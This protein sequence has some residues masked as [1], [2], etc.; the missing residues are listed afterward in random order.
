M[1]EFLAL[2]RVTLRAY[3]PHLPAAVAARCG[4]TLTDLPALM[5]G[6]D[7]VVLC[8]ANTTEANA[9]VSRELVNR[10]APGALL[11]NVGRSMLVDM[12]A[13]RERLERREIFAALDVFDPEPLEA[14]SPFRR[15][16]N[17][18]LTPHRAGGVL[19]SVRGILTMLADDFEAHLDGRPRQC[20][21][22]TEQLHCLPE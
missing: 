19:D 3:D 12:E 16:E 14:D 17:A 6:S 18:W 2:F 20:A 13:L 15:L 1:A 10:L 5:S 11:V 21:L 9:L 22:T 4:A 8:A 7:V